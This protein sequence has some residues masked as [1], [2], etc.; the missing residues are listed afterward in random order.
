LDIWVAI[1]R[2]NLPFFEQIQSLKCY[3]LDTPFHSDTLTGSTNKGFTPPPSA[4][5]AEERPSQRCFLALNFFDEVASMNRTYASLFALPILA[6]AAARVDAAGTMSFSTTAPSTAGSNQSDVLANATIPGGTTPGGGTYNS[7]AFSDNGGPP[8]QTFTTP[9]GSALRLNAISLLGANTGGGN[10]GNGV[11]TTG[12]LWSIRISSVSG[13]NLTPL[14][15][16]SAI[17]TVTGALGNEWYT[18][19]F[20]APDILTLAP[21]TQYAFELFSDTTNGNSYLGFAADTTD[22]YAGGTAFNSAGATR[23]FT[24]NTLGNLATHGY[25]RTFVVALAPVPE[26]STLLLLSL[27]AFAGLVRFKRLRR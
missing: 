14:D 18:W 11:F 4:R 22:S 10:S 12:T 9:A 21:S 13:A 5:T 20:S 8:G 1:F 7:Q 6:F 2:P 16:I 15:T 24:D 3:F 17:P 27:G 25:D 26:P 23:S 19:T